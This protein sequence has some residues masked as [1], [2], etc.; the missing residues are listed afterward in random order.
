MPFDMSVVGRTFEP[1][2]HTYAAKDVALYALA[3]GAT[4]AELDLLLESRGPKVLPTFPV[5]FVMTA[6]T[7]ALQRLGGNIIMLVHGAQ[8]CTV[9]RPLPTEAEVVTT[10]RIDAVYDKGKGA[11][12]IFRTESTDDAGTHLAETEWQIFYRGEGG[13]GGDRGPEAAVESPAEGEVP[14]AAVDMP[15]ATNQALLYRW[16][17]GDP[18]PIH[19]EPA[20]AEQVGFPKPILHG[21]CTFGHAARAVVQSCCAGDSDRLRSIEG[22]FSKPVLPGQVLSTHIWPRPHGALF[23]TSV[24]DVP[25]LVRGRADIT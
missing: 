20:V 15:T 5:V 8:R 25:V 24:G 1:F 9:P 7:D 17:S 22:R 18:N 11:L 12:A 4:D 3:C 14:T 10:A 6:M 19:L 16:A 2:R 21:L 23:S 13:F